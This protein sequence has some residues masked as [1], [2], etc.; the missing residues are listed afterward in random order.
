MHSRFFNFSR[1]EETPC[2]KPEPSEIQ[3][4]TKSKQYKKSNEPEAIVIPVER[5]ALLAESTVV[6]QLLQ[7]PMMQQ[8]FE[9]IANCEEERGRKRLK[10]ALKTNPEFENLAFEML[11]AIG[12]HQD[13]EEDEDQTFTNETATIVKS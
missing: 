2:L 6:R 7:N 8:E 9:R 3:P 5:L 11:K 4:Q 1:S 12:L 10:K 13:Q